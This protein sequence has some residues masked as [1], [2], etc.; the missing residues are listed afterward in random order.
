MTVDLHTKEDSSLPYDPFL[1]QETNKIK[2]HGSALNQI[3]RDFG[4]HIGDSLLN[5]TELTNQ[6]QICQSHFTLQ[7]T[8]KFDLLGISSQNLESVFLFSILCDLFLCL[9]YSLKFI[10]SLVCYFW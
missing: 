7:D 2:I 5:S 9:F 1:L 3:P 6:M 10:F 8:H 4:S